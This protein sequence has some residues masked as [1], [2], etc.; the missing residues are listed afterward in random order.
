M[1]ATKILLNSIV[2]TPGAKFINSDIKY[3]NLNTPMLRYKYMHIA[4]SM[5]TLDII[6]ACNVLLL[7]KSGHVIVEICKGMYVLPQAS[8]ITHDL[9]VEHLS[10]FGCFPAHHTPGLCHHSTRNIRFCLVIDNFGVKY[11][12]TD[13]AKHLNVALAILYKIAL[14]W[15]GALYL[16]P[17][18]KWNHKS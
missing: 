8:K 11:I 4:I 6:D 10:K 15:S 1:I 9:L 2:Y 16:G 5:I 7:I 12:N 17:T 13:D 3:F 18:L 14:Y